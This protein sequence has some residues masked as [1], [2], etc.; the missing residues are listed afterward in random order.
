MLFSSCP[1]EVP[2]VKDPLLDRF[3]LHIAYEY[4]VFPNDVDVDGD[5]H[6]ADH[7]DSPVAARL[8]L[9]LASWN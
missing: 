5:I 8:V 6:R 2:A 4:F 1:H 9:T 7:C 3:K